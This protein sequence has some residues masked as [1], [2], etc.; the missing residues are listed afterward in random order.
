V[1]GLI[2]SFV[3]YG[4]LARAPTLLPTQQLFLIGGSFSL[5]GYDFDQFG[6]DQALLLTGSVGFILPFLRQPMPISKTLALPAINPNIAV[7]A[8]VGWTGASNATAQAS[9]DRLGTRVTSDNQTVPF[10]GWACS[11][12]SSGSG[13]PGLSRP[14]GTGPSSSRSASTCNDLAGGGTRCSRACPRWAG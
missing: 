8:Y 2:L 1:N 10:S 14:T 13:W 6:G 11:A 4:G 7:L 5:P 9:L 3:G 12:T